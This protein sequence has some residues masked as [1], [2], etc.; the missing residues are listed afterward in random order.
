MSTEKLGIIKA[1]SNQDKPVSLAIPWNEETISQNLSDVDMDLSFHNKRKHASMEP[2][3]PLLSNKRALKDKI[4]EEVVEIE[5]GLWTSTGAGLIENDDL[6]N[7][8]FSPGSNEG[9]SK[10]ITKVEK[11]FKGKVKGFKRLSGIKQAARAK[12]MGS[13]EPWGWDIRE[14]K[15]LVLPESV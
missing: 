8:V 6:V 15:V 5:P 2:L 3:E 11:R 10:I 14:I 12:Y 4:L 13:E 7:F 9:P 1:S